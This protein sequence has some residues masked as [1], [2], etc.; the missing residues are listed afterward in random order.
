MNMGHRRFRAAL[1]GRV[2][3]ENGGSRRA[4]RPPNAESR[5]SG[6]GRLAVPVLGHVIVVAAEGRALVGTALVELDERA[7]AERAS[8]GLDPVR[9][10][11]SPPAGSADFRFGGRFHPEGVTTLA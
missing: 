3:L 9:A 10:G 8:P 5:A 6:G 11:E 1:S 7:A 2:R 4:V